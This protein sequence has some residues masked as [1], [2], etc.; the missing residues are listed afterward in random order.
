MESSIVEELWNENPDAIL[1]IAPDDTVLYWNRAAEVIFGYTSAEACG[2]KL[3]DL[4]IPADQL[5]EERAFLEEVMTRNLAVYESV[6][7]RKDGSLVHV[8]VSSK[9]LKEADGR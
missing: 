1:A 8:S 5:K 2:Q 3:A 7:Q 4:V 9:A 6:R